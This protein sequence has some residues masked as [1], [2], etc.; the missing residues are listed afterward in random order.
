MSSQPISLNP[1]TIIKEHQSLVAF[2]ARKYS[3]YGLS[4][5]DLMQE[6]MLGLLEACKRYDADKNVS[7]E[8]YAG[9]WVKKYIMQ[10]LNL[11]TK[12]SLNALGLNENDKSIAQPSTV[13]ESSDKLTLP[14]DMPTIEQTVLRLSY[15]QNKT[16]RE[17]ASELSLTLEKTRRLRDKALRR[18]KL[19]NTN[20]SSITTIIP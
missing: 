15:E 7:F 11:E 18:L 10:A 9:H 3:T 17:I 6:G 8:T 4:I 2:Y 19:T 5:D 1:E 14:S 16:L 20:P 12:Q 13:Q